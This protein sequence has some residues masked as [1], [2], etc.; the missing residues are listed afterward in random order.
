MTH[1]IPSQLEM[2]TKNRAVISE[3]VLLGLHRKVLIWGGVHVCVYIYNKI[4]GRNWKGK[5]VS[6]TLIRSCSFLLRD[7]ESKPFLVYVDSV[8]VV[9]VHSGGTYGLKDCNF[10]FVWSGFPRQ[11]YFYVQSAIAEPQILKISIKS[12]ILAILHV[13]DTQS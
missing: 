5:G 10:F 11:L 3:K 9:H 1:V 4:V 2:E 12:Q 8:H 13:G 7:E 6:C